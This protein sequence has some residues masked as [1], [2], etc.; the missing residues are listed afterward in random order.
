MM[1][2]LKDN[3]DGY[4]SIVYDDTI[5]IKTAMTNIREWLQTTVV[6]L[7]IWHWDTAVP[8]PQPSSCLASGKLCHTGHQR[9]ED[10]GCYIPKK[11]LL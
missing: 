8:K 5:W 4:D 7:V 9:H 3:K 1:K 2:V 6:N 11:L 10:N